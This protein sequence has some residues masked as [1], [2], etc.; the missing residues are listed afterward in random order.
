M[1]INLEI[2]LEQ[3]NEETRIY[4]PDVFLLP[5]VT[6]IQL[7]QSL[8]RLYFL[9]QI[10]SLENKLKKE[11]YLSKV[12]EVNEFWDF[13][14][15]PENLASVIKDGRLIQTCFVVIFIYNSF[16]SVNHKLWGFYHYLDQKMVNFWVYHCKLWCKKMCYFFFISFTHIGI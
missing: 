1:Y 16:P 8:C 14:C 2:V 15:V 11:G 3:E 10:I 12:H 9:Y 4:V 6:G 13:I 5:T 7:Y